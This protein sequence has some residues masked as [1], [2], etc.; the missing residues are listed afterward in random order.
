MGPRPSRPRAVSVAWS[1]DAMHGADSAPS[2]RQVLSNSGVGA[3]LAAG[4]AG[5]TIPGRRR[6]VA[7]TGCGRGAGAGAR[8]AR[9]AG[10]R[11]SGARRGGGGAG[12]GRRRAARRRRRRA[13]AGVVG[14]GRAAAGCVVV[15]VV[16][17]AC[18]AS[19]ILRIATSGDSLRTGRGAV[20]PVVAVA[21]AGR[22]HRGRGR[23]WR[24]G[25]R[26]PGA[27]PSGRSARS[28]GWRGDGRS[29][30]APHGW[31][32]VGT[33]SRLMVVR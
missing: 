32:T 18:S 15:V 20:R 22:G 23:P 31:R 16:V 2:A 14:G 9:G 3:M 8:R 33:G 30:V 28:C 24:P 19:M 27:T 17:A 12:G 29:V 7:G 5:G 1:V 21:A 25:R 10:R 11:R 26:P 4:L 6:R 13:V